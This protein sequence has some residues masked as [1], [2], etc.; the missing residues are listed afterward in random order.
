MG[1]GD[2]L[3]YLMKT[4]DER[5]VKQLQYILEQ[6]QVQQPDEEVLSDNEVITPPLFSQFQEDNDVDDIEDEED[7][8]EEEETD[9]IIENTEGMPIGEE[10]L[11]KEFQ[12]NDREAIQQTFIIRQQMD[13][14]KRVNTS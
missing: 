12:L 14:N 5:S 9:D 10:L 3:K 7:I 6:L 4:S 1:L 8:A 11:T 2:Q 13:E